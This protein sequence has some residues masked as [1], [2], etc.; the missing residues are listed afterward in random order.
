MLFNKDQTVLIQHPEGN[1]RSAYTIP[2]TATT[3]ADSAFAGCKAL[4]RVAIGRGVS[5]IG[6]RAFRSCNLADVVIP[7]NVARIGERAFLFCTNLTD[8]LIRDGVTNIAGYAFRSCSSVTNVTIGSGIRRVGYGTFFDCANLTAVCFHGDAPVVQWN[9]FNNADQATARYLPGTSGWGATFG[10]RPTALWK[11][12][13]PVILST[14]T[15]L[16]VRPDDLGFVISWAT[17]ASV[18]VEASADLDSP[19]WSPMGTNALVDGS[20]VFVDP[21]WRSSFSRFYRLRSP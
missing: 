10:G 20:S 17:N 5:V 8:V 11:L 16:G 13:Y 12:P 9:L 2:D 3:I 4:Q 19:R 14:G 1:P 15:S 18:V 21:D 6:N 7:D